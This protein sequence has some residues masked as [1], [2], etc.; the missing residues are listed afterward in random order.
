MKS[1]L[2]KSV[3]NNADFTEEFEFVTSFYSGDINA[4][5]LKIQLETLAAQI[6]MDEANLVDVVKYMKNLTSSQRELYSEV[7]ILIKIILVNPST[8]STS[9]RSF[10]AMRRIKTY[11]RSSMSQSRLNAMMTLHVHKDRMD[12]ISLQDVAKAFINS[13]HRKS[14]FGAFD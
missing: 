8:N 10:S 11:L 6:T 4:S 5:T 2:I 12:K 3:S 7:V 14:I 13:D 9:E 1:L